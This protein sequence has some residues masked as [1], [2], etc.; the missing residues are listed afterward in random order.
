MTAAIY[1]LIFIFPIIIGWLLLHIRWIIQ[2]RKTGARKYYA[3]FSILP[4]LLLIT[5]LFSQFPGSV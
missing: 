2:V 3:Y 4:M 1:L 5:Y